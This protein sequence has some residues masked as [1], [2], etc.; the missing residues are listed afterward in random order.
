MYR[1]KELKVKCSLFD[2]SNVFYLCSLKSLC[3]QAKFSNMCFS[4]QQNKAIVTKGAVGKV[5][6]KKYFLS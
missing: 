4:L 6:G 5:T 1:L 3:L 2:G